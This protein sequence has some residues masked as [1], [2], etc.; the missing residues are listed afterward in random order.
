M[1]GVTALLL[2]AFPTSDISLGV[3][4][5]GDILFNFDLCLLEVEPLLRRCLLCSNFRI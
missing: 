4:M 2:K 3:G 5:M 1:N